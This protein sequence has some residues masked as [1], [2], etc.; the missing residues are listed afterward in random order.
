M[1]NWKLVKR[2]IILLGST[3]ISTCKYLTVTQSIVCDCKLRFTFT[4]SNGILRHL[5]SSLNSHSQSSCGCG[6]EEDS[7]G[8]FH[9]NDTELLVASTIWLCVH[10]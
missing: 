8:S 1:E 10:K 7:M 2:V 6:C 5:C 9:V 4:V 3:F